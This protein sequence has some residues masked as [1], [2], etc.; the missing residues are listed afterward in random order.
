MKL[1]VQGAEDLVLRGSESMLRSQSIDV[2]VSEAMFVPHY[3]NGVL[4]H[5]LATLLE[6]FGYSLDNI[7][8]FSSAR[9]GQLCQCN[10]IFVS[11]NV[12]RE[13]IL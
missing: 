8:G 9:N 10:T 5:A 12:R 7:Y 4:H 1:D 2:I 3:E 13:R 11:E 6:Q